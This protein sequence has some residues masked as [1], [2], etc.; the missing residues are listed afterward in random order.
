MAFGAVR[1]LE[2]E[3]QEITDRCPSLCALNR[4]VLIVDACLCMLVFISVT[5]SVTRTVPS[6]ITGAHVAAQGIPHG[7][8][9]FMNN[10]F[11]TT[12]LQV[13]AV[14]VFGHFR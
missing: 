7:C 13:C 14:S 3:A 4:V 5:P 8:P 1:R 9:Q 10:C 12:A 6:H 11:A 2:S